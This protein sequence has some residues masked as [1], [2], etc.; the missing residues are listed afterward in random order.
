MTGI[1]EKL[2]M[3]DVIGLSLGVQPISVMIDEMA[4]KSKYKVQPKPH[5]G[6]KEMARRKKQIG[7]V[8]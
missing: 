4:S 8:K 5:Q 3:L 1:R 2:L 6:S 7:G